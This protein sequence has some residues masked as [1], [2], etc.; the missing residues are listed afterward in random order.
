VKTKGRFDISIAQPFAVLTL[1]RAHK[2]L[3]TGKEEPEA[4]PL[5]RDKPAV[6]FAESIRKELHMKYIMATTLQVVKGRLV[7]R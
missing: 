5:R 3:C 6:C 7:P 1:C 4:A 2:G